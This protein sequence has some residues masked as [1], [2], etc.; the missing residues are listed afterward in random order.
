MVNQISKT[1]VNCFAR[2][3]SSSWRIHTQLLFLLGISEQTLHRKRYAT[4][5][6]SQNRF[7]STLKRSK[8]FS[9][10][11]VKKWVSDVYNNKTCNDSYKD[12]ALLFSLVRTSRRF[13]SD[14]HYYPFFRFCFVFTGFCIPLQTLQPFKETSLIGISNN[15]EISFFSG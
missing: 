8:S 14:F 7:S 5:R 11:G 2:L 12:M 6:M 4:F 3:G 15:N 1:N 9:G 10:F 13:S